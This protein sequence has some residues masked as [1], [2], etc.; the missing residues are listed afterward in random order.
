LTGP[1]QQD[2]KFRERVKSMKRLTSLVAALLIM[3]LFLAAC[4]GGATPET[5]PTGLEEG[6]KKDTIV[7]RAV[8]DQQTFDPFGTADINDQRIHYQIF[9]SLM[10]QEPDGSLVP[11][12]CTDYKFNETGD[13]ITFTIREGVKFHNG[14]VMTADD[15][16]F[17]LNTAI[18][19]GF[20]SKVTSTMDRAEKVDDKTVKLILKY[21]F[22]PILG[23]LVSSSCAIV[24]QKVY[25]AD[26]DAF[27]RNPVGAGPYMLKE[28]K[29]GEKIVLEAFSDY[30]RGEAP[31]KNLVVRIIVDD[32]AA[33]MAL[34]SGELD[35]MQPSQAYTDRDAIINNP[36][37][38]YYEAEQACT[39]LVAFNNVKGVFTDK[40][41]R[42][43]VARAIDREELILGAVN[44]MATPVEAGLVPITPQY[45]HGFKGLEYDLE[46]AKQL[47]IDAGYPNGLDVTMR[48][49]AAA[50]YTKP[51]EVLQAQLKKIGINVK[52]EPMERGTWFDVAYAGGDYE[53]TFYAHAISVND[54]DFCSYPFLHSSEAD[55]K[56]NNYMGIKNAELDECLEKARTSQDEAERKAYYLRACEIIRDESLFVP[57]YTGRR[58]MAAV[59]ELKGVQAD[60]WMRYYKYNY[61][62]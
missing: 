21:P 34:E 44:G 16:V 27:G 25:E 31:I 33:L 24:P 12:L 59:K 4:S 30:Y 43:A 2:S 15:V 20:T 32:A 42:E 46:K 1:R 14:D 13:E 47:V 56:G 29:P 22:A 3:S 50:N 18:A 54:A 9:D 55:G 26:K 45:P 19:S 8:A 60:P 36:N 17:S 40:R 51:A 6:P 52:I 37:L 61:S 53:M 35:L 62:W 5:P 7:E 10:R 57:C 41:L 11:A 28:V 38:V 49:I 23:C 58:T 48:V 39:F